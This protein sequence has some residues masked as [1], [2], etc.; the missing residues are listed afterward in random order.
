MTDTTEERPNRR[1]IAKAKTTARVLEAARTLFARDGFQKATI[2]A[3][4]NEAGMS[5]GAVF[6]SFENKDALYFAAHGH[7]PITPEEGVIL[8]AA[9]RIAKPWVDA[10]FDEATRTKIPEGEAALATIDAALAMFP[11]PETEPCNT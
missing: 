9:L 4:A 5:T 6:A 7:D 10:G 8:L 2:R 1:Q 11:Q 3:I